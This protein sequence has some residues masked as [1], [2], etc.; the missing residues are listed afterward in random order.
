MKKVEIIASSI[1]RNIRNMNYGS[2]YAAIKKNI[3]LWKI[4]D[5]RD[6]LCN[7]ARIMVNL[8]INKTVNSGHTSPARHS[9]KL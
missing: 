4:K 2:A 3:E 1:N 7:D 9:P 8:Y 6:L 5:S